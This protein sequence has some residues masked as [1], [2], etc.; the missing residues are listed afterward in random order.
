MASPQDSTFD[1]L[2]DAHL[3]IA[4]LL[5]RG[6]AQSGPLPLPHWFRGMLKAVDYNPTAAEAPISAITSTLYDDLL[7]D[8][9]QLSFRM[10]AQVTGEK[11]GGEADVAAYTDGLIEKLQ[12]P[13]AALHFSDVY[14]PLVIGGIILFDRASLPDEK[15]GDSLTAVSS[16]LQGRRAELSADDQIAYRVVEKVIER[17]RQKYGYQ[18]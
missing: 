9:S 2:S 11:I 16:A 15:L 18:V 12:T 7:R 10:I 4:H 3:N 5:K 17:A 1:H 8:A 14:M 13:D 6:T